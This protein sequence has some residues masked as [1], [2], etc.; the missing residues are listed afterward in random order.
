[1]ESLFVR[2]GDFFSNTYLGVL[3][4]F[5]LSVVPLLPGKLSYKTISEPNK[6]GGREAWVTD[7]NLVFEDISAPVVPMHQSP[8]LVLTFTLQDLIDDFSQ[9]LA[10]RQ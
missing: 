1:M 2:T 4:I 9:L 8:A 10:E 3:E 6:D 7:L 5:R